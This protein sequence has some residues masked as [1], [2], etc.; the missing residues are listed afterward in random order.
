MTSTAVMVETRIGTDR[1]ERSLRPDSRAR[2]RFMPCVSI[3]GR[4]DADIKR[5]FTAADYGLS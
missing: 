2:R 3:S 1:R 5:N 4:E